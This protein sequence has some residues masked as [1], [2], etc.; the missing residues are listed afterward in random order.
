M[1]ETAGWS[2][3]NTR[4]EVSVVIVSWNVADLLRN[5]LRSVFDT[6]STDRL[7]AEVIVVDNASRDDTSS[8]IRREFPGVEL[9]VNAE[10]VGFARANNQGFK[11]AKADLIFILN[12]DTVVQ[13]GALAELKAAFQRHP[14]AGIIGPKILTDAGLIQETTARRLPN[15]ASVLW[16]DSLKF[17]QSP[18]MGRGLLRRLKFP[19]DY[20]EE[21]AVEAVSGAAM[22]ARRGLIETLGGFSGDFLHTGEDVDLCARAGRSGAA[23]WYVPHA[24]VV[25]LG[26]Q[27]SRQSM[28][29]SAINGRLSGQLYF[30]RTYGRSAAVWYRIIILLVQM[31]VLLLVG[32]IKRILGMETREQLETRIQIAARIIRWHP[33]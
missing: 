9:V 31:P 18:G 23:I 16:I 3:D 20:D 19:Y 27:S 11:L 14:E 26:G 33:E 4:P 32:I 29:R 21:Q 5:C 25:H 22:M 30:L 7:E 8:M 2:G 13:P 17:H 1:F 24:I 12:P 28:V 6:A 10:N 15:L